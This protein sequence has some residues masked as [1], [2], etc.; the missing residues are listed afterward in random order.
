VPGQ[1]QISTATVAGTFEVGDR[2]TIRL[3]KDEI[4]ALFGAEGNPEIVGRT[5]LTFKTKLYA[6]AS[7]LLFFSGIN[8]ADVWNR[9]HPTVPGANFINMASQS[10]GSQDLTVAQVYQDRMAI[11]SRTTVQIWDIKADEAQNAALQTLENT[12]TRS[13][14]SVIS[15]G[16]TDTFYYADSGVRSLRA[17]DSS[18]AAFVSDVGT[19]ID[20][21]LSA[22]A[23]TLTD[24]QIEAAFAVLEPGDDRYW[25]AIG[26]RIYVFSYFPGSKISAW[27]YYD[28]TDDLGGSVE[29]LARSASKLYAR[30]GDTIYTYGGS[31]GNTYPDDDE[32]EATIET[33][34]FDAKTPA[35]KKNLLGFDMAGQGVWEV[36]I[37]IDPN[38]TSVRMDVGTLDKITYPLGRAAAGYPQLTHFAVRAVCRKA[39]YASISNMA[40]HYHD[41]SEAG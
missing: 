11:L 5:A 21:H 4:T 36:S 10:E 27:S 12:G 8:R 9:D 40:I 34:F 31:N 16:N 39:G 26:A 2:F 3:T 1:A 7:S 14:R 18:N 32:I 23:K 29:V 17:R 25:L 22:Y 20:N 33:P 37:L 19:A 38:D 28:I 41:P 15:Y 35:T 13:P 6:T 30:S 24:A